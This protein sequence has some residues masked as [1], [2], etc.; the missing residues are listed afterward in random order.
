MRGQ[1][2]RSR[3]VKSKPAKAK[4]SGQAQTATASERCDARLRC[5]DGKGLSGA[6]GFVLTRSRGSTAVSL[7]GR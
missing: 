6:P 1:I 4:L 2:T 5:A 7:P 3:D